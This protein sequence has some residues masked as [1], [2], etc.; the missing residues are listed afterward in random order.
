[1]FYNYILQDSK[2]I[3]NLL[4]LNIKKSIPAGILKLV[5]EQLIKDLDRKPCQTDP[6]DACINMELV[7]IENT[8][9]VSRTSIKEVVNPSKN[10][11]KLAIDNKNSTIISDEAK[12]NVSS[13]AQ[14]IPIVG[15][16]IVNDKKKSSQLSIYDIMNNSELKKNVVKPI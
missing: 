4:I 10:T 14:R 2:N 1:M 7:N 6:A 12:T 8:T 5:N 16:P 3:E 13:D 9:Q 11:L 15:A